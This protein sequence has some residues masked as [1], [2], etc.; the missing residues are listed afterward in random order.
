VSGKGTKFTVELPRNIMSS[1]GKVEAESI[2]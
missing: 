1:A 2:S